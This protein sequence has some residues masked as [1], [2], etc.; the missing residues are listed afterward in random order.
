M[1]GLVVQGRPQRRASADMLALVAVL[2][3]A[4]ASGDA[5]PIA[6][7]GALDIP[8]AVLEFDARDGGVRPASWHRGPEGLAPRR[9]E[10]PGLDIAGP[11]WNRVTVKV[12]AVLGP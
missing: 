1:R 7:A 2:Y 6:W 8:P 3:G 4:V 5:L 11:G 9:P 12:L 10:T